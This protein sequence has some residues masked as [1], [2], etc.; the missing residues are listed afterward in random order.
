MSDAIYHHF[1]KTIDDYDTVADKVVMKN[2]ELHNELAALVPIRQFALKIL[3]LGCGTGHGMSLLLKKLPYAYCTGIDFSPRM[4]A[5][6]RHNLQAFSDRIVLIEANFNEIMFS[7][8]YDVIVS[9]IAIHNAS[10]QQKR[11]LF[12]KIFNALREGGIF[13]NADFI[14]GESLEFNNQYKHTYKTYLEQQLS[15]DELQAWMRHAFEED[16][17][18]KLSEQFALLRGYDFREIK[19]SWQ[20]HNEAVYS[21][22]K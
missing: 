9:A 13:I 12:R 21:A 18:M 19:L 7:E 10:H 6:A 14:E 11:A 16:Q 5:K 3:D 8:R 2:D 4:I 1:S 15:G 22:T 17:P 20:Y